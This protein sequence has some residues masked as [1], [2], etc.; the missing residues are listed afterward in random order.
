MDSRHVLGGK[1]A[2][3]DRK[4]GVIRGVL[5]NAVTSH[6]ELNGSQ[7]PYTVNIATVHERKGAIHCAV[8]HLE[9]VKIVQVVQGKLDA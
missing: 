8:C 5:S 2:S 1:N 6:F 3:H 7:V 4:E 9:N